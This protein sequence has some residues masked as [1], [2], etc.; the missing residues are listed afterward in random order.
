[1][2]FSPPP[3]D[4]PALAGP[5]VC[6]HHPTFVTRSAAGLHTVPV[7]GREVVLWRDPYRLELAKDKRTDGD[8]LVQWA[9]G[10]PLPPE[11]PASAWQLLNDAPPFTNAKQAKKGGWTIRCPCECEVCQQIACCRTRNSHHFRV[12]VLL[13]RTASFLRYLLPVCELHAIFIQLLDIII[14][15]ALPRSLFVYRR[16]GIVGSLNPVRCAV[17]S[18]DLALLWCPMA[19]QTPAVARRVASIFSPKRTFPRA[20]PGMSL[21]PRLPRLPRR[22]PRLQLWLSPMP[23]RVPPRSPANAP[24][25]TVLSMLRVQPPF[26]WK[27]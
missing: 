23:T 10:G 2:M 6:T 18:R 20:A 15:F 19:P 5:P 16:R 8:A 22:L 1:M 7:R 25:I 26:T 13:V 14:V 24:A 17:R 3:P 12:I 11:W 9:I 21:P 4:P 27:L